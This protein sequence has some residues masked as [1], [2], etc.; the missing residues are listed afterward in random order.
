MRKTLLILCAILLLHTVDAKAQT[1]ELDSIKTAIDLH[2]QRDTTRL[3]MLVD[4][5]LSAINVNTSQALPLMQEVVSISKELNNMRGIEIGYIYL[6]L[7]YSDRG[8]FA[9]ANLYADTAVR[10]LERDTNHFARVNLGYLLNNLGGD[11]LKLGDYQKAIDNYTKAAEILERDQAAALPSVYEGKAAVYQ[12]LQQIDK[13]IEYHAKAIKAAEKLGDK[14]SLARRYMNYAELLAK[15][16]RYAEA[17]SVLKTSQPLLAQTKDPIAQ[18]VF[19]QIRGSIYQHEKKYREAIAD[20]RASYQIGLDNDD[21]YQQIAL[22]DPL[23]RSLLDAG[24]A[25]EAKRMND[26]LL[27]KATRYQMNF[28]RLNAYSNTARWCI[29]NNDPATAYKF[30]EMK[31][32]LSDSISS[33][34]MK[35]KIA[36]TETRYR[37]AGKD[38][39]IQTLQAEKEIRELQLLQKS[40]LNYILVGGFVALLIIG[41]LIYR[42]YRQTQ[43]IQQQRISELETEKQLAATEAIIEGEEKERSRLAQDLHDGLGGLLSGI[44]YSLNNMKENLIMTPGNAQAF[45]Q[46]IGMLDHSI[47]EMRRVAHN[48]MPENLLKFGLD[49]AMRDFCSEMQL[50]GMLQVHYQSLGLKDKSMD[51]GLSVTVYRVTQE[52]L[53]NI[54][55][56]AGATQAIVQIAATDSQLTITVE[57]NGKGLAD[58]TIK[59]AQGIGWKNIYSRVQYQK[60]TI[61]IQSQPGKGTSVYIEFPVA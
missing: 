34:E 22:L 31:M 17:Q 11:N 6:Q 19:Y 1:R 37:V 24:E 36:L 5:V 30:L 12:E 47:S 61:N 59:S 16:E 48:L 41:T 9:M 32:Q 13:A 25:T 38:R 3:N 60:G 50:N 29:L 58:E 52:L 55:K 14:V 26:T 2:P 57:D 20:F 40:V 39:E 4:Y 23:I 28:G 45:E 8:D 42:T 44:K 27:E 56:H 51:Q 10:Y 15:Q 43:K 49:A 33:D 35:K 46:S 21:K 7:Y 54:V 53:N 18:A